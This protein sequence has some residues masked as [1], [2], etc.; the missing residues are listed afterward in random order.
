MHTPTRSKTSTTASY[1]PGVLLSVGKPLWLLA[2]S[3]WVVESYHDGCTM[4]VQG[5]IGVDAVLM[6]R[7]S[8]I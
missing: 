3:V 2:L 4:R 6:T 1:S 7:R 8:G 5:M